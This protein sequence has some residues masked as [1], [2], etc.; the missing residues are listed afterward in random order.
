MLGDIRGA[1]NSLE[2]EDAGHRF[3]ASRLEVV[4][5]AGQRDG[6]PHGPRRYY[7]PYAPPPHEQALVHQLL[8]RGSHGGAADPQ[9]RRLVVERH[10]AA[11]VE[12]LI[13]QSAHRA[14]TLPTLAITTPVM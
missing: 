14:S 7:G 4:V 8:Y 11:V 13:R 5:E 10:G 1:G 2:P 12:R 9:P 3:P 6:P